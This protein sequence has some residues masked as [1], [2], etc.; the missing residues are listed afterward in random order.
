MVATGIVA[1]LAA[2]RA[3]AV[4][5]PGYVD[6]DLL[7][8]ARI[9]VVAGAAAGASGVVAEEAERTARA[10]SRGL[11]GSRRVETVSVERA[12]KAMAKLELR[13]ARDL[14]KREPNR[15][16]RLDTDRAAAL[17]DRCGADAVLVP[18]WDT[19]PV[20]P[21]TAGPALVRL[22]VMLVHQVRKQI[23]WEDAETLKKGPPLETEAV[24]TAAAESAARP[25][26]D[27]FMTAWRLAGER[28]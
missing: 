27:R 1:L 3:G 8:R 15:G 2:G 10:L 12:S 17:A 6:L 21:G 4:D 22:H 26:I 18:I 24:T 23:I 7:R 16:L 25:L 20:E 9:V 19:P 28:G 14:F 11:A 5:R 13:T